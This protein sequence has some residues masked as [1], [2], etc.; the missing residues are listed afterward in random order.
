[1][2]KKY[3]ALHSLQYKYFVRLRTDLK[4]ATKFPMP[5]PAWTHWSKFD[6]GKLYIQTRGQTIDSNDHNRGFKDTFFIVGRSQSDKVFSMV[7]TYMQC[8]RR[9]E[10]EQVCTPNHWSWAS[11]ECILKVHLKTCLPGSISE[12][13]PLER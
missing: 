11:P 4:S 10:N 1:M 2:Q 9:E 5:F 13:F 7:S 3:E 12:T 8:Q 6:Q